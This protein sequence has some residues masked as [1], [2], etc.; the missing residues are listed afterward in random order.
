MLPCIFHTNII[1]CV[2][3]SWKITIVV[4]DERFLLYYWDCNFHR[5]YIQLCCFFNNSLFS[6]KNAENFKYL[7]YAPHLLIKINVYY[8][9]NIFDIPLLN[10]SNE[11]NLQP[12]SMYYLLFCMSFSCL[13]CI[14]LLLSL[15]HFLDPA[16]GS[17]RVGTAEGK[18][19]R[20]LCDT[21]FPWRLNLSIKFI[22]N[23]SGAKW[24][25]HMLSLSS[26]KKLSIGRPV[27]EIQFFQFGLCLSGNLI[28]L[29]P[30]ST[31]TCW[32]ASGGAGFLLQNLQSATAHPVI[33][34]FVYFCPLSW[35]HVVTAK[36]GHPHPP[37]TGWHFIYRV[38]QRKC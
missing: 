12:D 31:G 21:F 2:F 34:T 7:S 8:P 19:A 22:L 26:P 10:K 25:E 9:R 15:I 3:N 28:I 6:V 24:I 18:S 11:N 33:F 38:G 5:H 29:N 1:P 35:R 37:F 16:I 13:A 32:R 20:T 14:L 4:S 36:S 17:L 27:L 23:I 30:T